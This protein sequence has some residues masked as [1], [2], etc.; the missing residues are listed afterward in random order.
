MSNTTA[1][2]RY[3]Q[4]TTHFETGPSI[5][6]SI[7]RKHMHHLGVPSAIIAQLRTTDSASFTNAAGHLVVI[8]VEATAADALAR[9]EDKISAALDNLAAVALAA[10]NAAAP[11]Q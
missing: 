7:Q 2:T 5:I 8:T 6:S 10:R 4:A 3:F 9:I 1:H 11:P